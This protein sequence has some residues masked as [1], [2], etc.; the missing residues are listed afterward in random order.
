MVSA[1]IMASG[2]SKRMGKNKL[3]LSYKGK[4]IIENV[5]DKVTS[6]DFKS[7]L[8]VYNNEEVLKICK[9]RNIRAIYNNEWQ[10]GQSKSINLGIK[11]S[12]KSDGYAFFTGDQ[13]LIDVETINVLLKEF[14]NNKDCIIVPNYNNKRGTP[15]I[16]SENFKEKLLEL[17]G[18]VGGRN[19]IKENNSCVKL[20][21]V[22]NEFILWDIDT[23][24]DYNRLLEI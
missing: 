2:Q 3:L 10:L 8:V 21:S 23:K 4:T 12:P 17:D 9:D 1:I 22:K 13:P 6:C 18:D 7:I 20:I 14:N 19:I 15:T 24:E 16:F 11:N 5:L